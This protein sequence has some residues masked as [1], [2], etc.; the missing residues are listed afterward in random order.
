MSID[1][2]IE[3]NTHME[4]PII[5]PDDTSIGFREV[6]CSRGSN[7]AAVVDAEDQLVG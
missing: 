6:D 5:P 7:G 3:V 4:K 1:S 2:Y